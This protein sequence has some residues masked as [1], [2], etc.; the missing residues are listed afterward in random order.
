MKDVLSLI[1]SLYELQI[2][3]LL[4]QDI[5]LLKLVHERYPDMDFNFDQMSVMSLEALRY[6]EDLGVKKSRSC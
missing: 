1:D 4:I 2:D 6:F 5:G 3:A